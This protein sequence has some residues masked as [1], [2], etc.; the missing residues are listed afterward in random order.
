M[1]KSKK[2]PA[3][4]SEQ[5]KSDILKRQIST[6]SID[7]ENLFFTRDVTLSG[8]FDL[9]EIKN[10]TFGKL[11]EAIP[12][13]TLLVDNEGRIIFAND[14]LSKIAIDAGEILNTS[15]SSLFPGAGE[16]KRAA[17][18][19]DDVLEFRK[20]QVFEGVIQFDGRMFWCRIHLRSIRF[21]NKRSVLALIEDLTA[22]KKQ[23]IISE[24]YH[25]LVQVFPM[26]IA[27]FSLSGPVSVKESR[28]L[29][30]ESV[31]NS[32]LVGGNLQFAKMS[33]MSHI[34]DLKGLHLRDLCSLEETVEN[35]Y[36]MW[37]ARNFPISS[38]ETR[39][40]SDGYARYYENT[41]VS[42]IKND[43]ILGLW[44][45]K[46][47]ITERKRSEDALRAARDKLED[48]VRERTAELLATNERL[49][50][51]IAERQKIEEE[52]E[53]MI[54]ELQDALTKVKT[55]TGLLPI[56]ASC[57]KIR[58]DKGFWQQVEVY[59]RDH[60][61]ANFTHSICPECATRLYPEIYDPDS[62]GSS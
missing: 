7:I 16:S 20:T 59:V 5:F 50:M 43:Y 49:I 32:K 58:D 33:G 56:C 55:L 57:N 40:L 12:I 11:L 23:L 1:E 35:N 15:F 41:L 52:L 60:T 48:R 28:D 61:E 21:R 17:Q 9:R 30:L 34:D 18:L 26:G 27:E 44:S 4:F 29:I 46:Q 39:E 47:D 24:K 13:P 36:R 19:I 51:E 3:D 31:L 10:V 62:A 8:S 45:M 42:N 38:Y 37:I 6:L 22:E 25:Q 54:I 53:N 2:P 14:G